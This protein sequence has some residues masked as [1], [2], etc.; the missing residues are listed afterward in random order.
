MGS[1]YRA[2]RSPGG[3]RGFIKNIAGNQGLATQ[4]LGNL[5][6]LI[7]EDPTLAS[8]RATQLADIVKVAEAQVDIPGDNLGLGKNTTPFC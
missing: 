1:R 8:T 5:A 3:G 7:Q 6:A 4:N 2:E